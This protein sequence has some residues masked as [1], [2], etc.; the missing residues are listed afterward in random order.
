V[1]NRHVLLIDDVIYTGRTL[2]GAMNEL[3][4]FGRPASITVAVWWHAK[5]GNYR[6]SRN[7]QRYTPSRGRN[8]ILR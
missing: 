6:L 7:W 4:D 1:N 3:F 8:G 5:G 2:R